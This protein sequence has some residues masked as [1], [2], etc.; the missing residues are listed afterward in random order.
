[1]VTACSAPLMQ[2]MVAGFLACFG[3]FAVIAMV[4]LARLMWNS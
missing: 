2:W 4:L 3:L 1:M